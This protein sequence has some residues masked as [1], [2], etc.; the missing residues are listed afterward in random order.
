MFFSFDKETLDSN[1]GDKDI[2][3]LDNH[4]HTHISWVLFLIK[5]NKVH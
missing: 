1:N 3:K 2:F 4:I 5:L